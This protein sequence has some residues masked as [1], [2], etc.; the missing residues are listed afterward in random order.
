MAYVMQHRGGPRVG[1]A[2]APAAPGLGRR[3]IW[4]HHITVK[5][6]GLGPEFAS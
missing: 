6:T 3:W 5:F 1:E 4:A 2:A